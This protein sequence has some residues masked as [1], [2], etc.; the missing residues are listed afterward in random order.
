MADESTGVNWTALVTAAAQMY[1]AY[2]QSQ[3]G[4]NVTSAA[5]DPANRSSSVAESSV[6]KYGEQSSQISAEGRA[7]RAAGYDALSALWGNSD[8]SRANAINDTQGAIAEIFNQYKI[9]D[10]PEIFSSMVSSGGYN[11]TSHQLMA[12]EAFANA[13]AKGAALRSQAILNYAEARNKQLAPLV[14]LL[15][16]DRENFGFDMA[17]ESSSSSS[18]GASSMD[19]YASGLNSTNTGNTGMVNAGASALEELFRK[20]PANSTSTDTSTV[21]NNSSSMVNY[22]V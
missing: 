10:L 21:F 6:E 9:K 4:S 15:N 20:K 13:T 1:G 3:A 8:Y 7:V 22:D 14:S 16:A 19:A 2:N 18:T 11:S 17:S 5:T 12:N